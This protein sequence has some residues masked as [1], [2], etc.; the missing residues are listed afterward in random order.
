MVRGGH[1]YPS[2]SAGAGRDAVISEAVGK[3]L[4]ITGG[5]SGILDGAVIPRD[6]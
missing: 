3:N 1:R 5:R 2:L 6:E 4:G